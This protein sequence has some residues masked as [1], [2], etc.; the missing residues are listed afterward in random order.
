MAQRSR[1][2][3]KSGVSETR[4]GFF[5]KHCQNLEIYVYIL[6]PTIKIREGGSRTSFTADDFCLWSVDNFSVYA[7]I[8]DDWNQVPKFCFNDSIGYPN[9]RWNIFEVN[10]ILVSITYGMPG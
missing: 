7:F 4:V 10:D 3:V 1:S 2:A 8:G 5:Y 9:F 6:D